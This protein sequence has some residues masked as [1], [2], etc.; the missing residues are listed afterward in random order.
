[1]IL[2]DTSVWIEVLR[3]KTGKI[4]QAFRERIGTDIC[5]FSRF[6]QLELLQGTPQL[7]GR[8]DDGLVVL[9]QDFRIVAANHAFCRRFGTYP[10]ALHGHHCQEAISGALYCQASTAGCPSVQCLANGEVQRAIWELFEPSATKAT[11]A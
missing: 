5:I 1:M 10:E 3:D 2:V 4:V 6:T 7:L 9:D 8:L 11:C